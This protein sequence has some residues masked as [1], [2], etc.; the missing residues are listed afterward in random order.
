MIPSSVFYKYKLQLKIVP[1]PPISRTCNSFG[2][3]R[4]KNVC[5]TLSQRTRLLKPYRKHKV[6]KKKQTVHINSRYW[7]ELQTSF[8]LIVNPLN[9]TDQEI[10]LAHPNT[11]E[12][13]FPNTPRKK[14]K[15]RS[16]QSPLRLVWNNSTCRAHKYNIFCRVPLVRFSR[17]VASNTFATIHRPYM[18]SWPCKGKRRFTRLRSSTNDCDS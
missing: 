11:Q 18:G 14:Q 1:S 16:S 4:I 13:P 15:N 9:S 8:V 10:N 3:V 5:N 2:V 17:P 7:S 6:H 12:C